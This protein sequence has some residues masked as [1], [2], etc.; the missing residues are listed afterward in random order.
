MELPLSELFALKEN[1][2][3]KKSKA[4]SMKYIHSAIVYLKL[5]LESLFGLVTKQVN[6]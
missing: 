4:S 5:L 2:V 6:I 3:F 1:K